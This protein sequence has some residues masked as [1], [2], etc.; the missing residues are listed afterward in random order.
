MKTIIFLVIMALLI[1]KFLDL[2]S[3]IKNINL[4]A[5]RNPLYRLLSPI[6]GAKNSLYIVAVI[7][8]CI[9]IAVGIEIMLIDTVYIRILFIIIGIVISIIQLMVALY[10]YGYNNRV[11]NFFLNLYNKILR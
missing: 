4:K 6:F 11:A 1:T 2:H 7:A 9:I 3:T 10:N 5:E 8:F